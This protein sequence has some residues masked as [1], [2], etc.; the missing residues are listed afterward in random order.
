MVSW[1]KTHAAHMANHG[2]QLCPFETP[3]G[4]PCANSCSTLHPYM[5]EFDCCFECKELV[6]VTREA[7]RLSTEG[8]PL[9]SVNSV[10]MKFQGLP[11]DYQHPVGSVGGLARET[12]C[13]LC[14]KP[15]NGDEPM[16]ECCGS[17]NDTACK[18]VWHASCH[19]VANDTAAP[20]QD[21]KLQCCTG[22]PDRAA[23]DPKDRFRE[24]YTRY[25]NGIAKPGSLR[26][27]SAARGTATNASTAAADDA[28]TAAAANALVLD[29]AAQPPATPAPSSS[30]PPAEVT[31]PTMVPPAS[32]VTPH[33]SSRAEP[34]ESND[35]DDRAPGGLTGKPRR[36]LS[37]QTEDA[38]AV[39]GAMGGACAGAGASASAGAGTGSVTGA[40]AAVPGAAQPPQCERDSQCTRGFRHGGKGGKCSLRPRLLAAADASLAPVSKGRVCGPPADV[41]R[42]DWKNT[43]VDAPCILDKS[44]AQCDVFR[45]TVSADPSGTFG[46]VWRG[47]ETPLPRHLWPKEKLEL[48]VKTP[49]SVT[50]PDDD[51]ESAKKERDDMCADMRLHWEARAA[52]SS[53]HTQHRYRCRVVVHRHTPT[54]VQLHLTPGVAGTHPRTAAAT[55]RVQHCAAAWV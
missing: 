15:A 40:G 36:S 22:W 33:M 35:T 25:R 5:L 47:K 26:S 6:T 8:V 38:A 50:E 21:G 7:A 28:S 30:T 42:I 54:A 46:H 10:W 24:P 14:T 23:I 11:G 44:G 1:K 18:L 39:G 34:A 4:E 51:D 12:L 20:P 17:R 19:A 41:G 45:A 55:R 31:P 53:A 37:N 27:K 16:L 49:K 48:A 43:A 2:R 29:V 32:L 13:A 9:V 52:P 3:I